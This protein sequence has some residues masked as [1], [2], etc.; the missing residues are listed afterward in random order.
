[1]QLRD[2]SA[3]KL[4]KLQLH[5]YCQTQF[6]N[7]SVDKYGKYFKYGGVAITQGN[8]ITTRLC[9]RYFHRSGSTECHHKVK[10]SL[11]LKM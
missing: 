5:F 8:L 9:T 2:A 1:M 6:A 3:S 4:K 11:Q 7:L 10:Q